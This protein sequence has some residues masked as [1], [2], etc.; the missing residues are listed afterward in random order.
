MNGDT[1]QFQQG[2]FES[3]AAVKQSV[4]SGKLAKSQS[5]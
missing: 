3:E 1:N 4:S 5:S 2:N